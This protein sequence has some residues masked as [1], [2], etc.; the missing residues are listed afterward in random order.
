[1]CVCWG[2]GVGGGAQHL[3]VLNPRYN[4]M[5]KKIQN[6]INVRQTTANKQARVQEQ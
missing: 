5:V 3:L 1:M 4:I 6:K 2:W